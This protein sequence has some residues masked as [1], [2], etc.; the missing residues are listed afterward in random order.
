MVFVE[1]VCPFCASTDA[2]FNHLNFCRVAT[3]ITW[4]KDEEGSVLSNDGIVRL[5]AGGNPQARDFLVK[6]GSAFD[7]FV[8]HEIGDSEP[9]KAVISKPLSEFFRSG[10]HVTHIRTGGEEQGIWDK[11]GQIS[12]PSHGSGL[13]QRYYTT[14][15]V[16]ET[17]TFDAGSVPYW[18]S[19]DPNERREH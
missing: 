15:N 7:Q 6:A 3:T 9:A 17:L 16:E 8:H 19:K 5:N 18:I 10:Y 2:V 1:V 12:R 13:E 11:V 4:R 14:L